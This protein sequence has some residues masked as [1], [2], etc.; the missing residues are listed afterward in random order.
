MTGSVAT[1]RQALPLEAD[2]LALGLRRLVV[3]TAT[4]P[5]VVRASHRSGPIATVLLHGAAGSWTTWT[6]LLRAAEDTGRPVRDVVAVDLPG[7]GESPPPRDR[8]LS[9]RAASTAVAQVVRTLGYAR[10]QVVGHSL[11]GFVALDLAAD[12][13]V[14]TTAVGL[15]SSTG[16][17]VVDAVRRPLVGGGRLPWFA[18][19]LLAMRTLAVLPGDGRAVLAALARLGLLPPLSSPLFADRRAVDPSVVA[20]LATEIRPTAFLDAARAAAGYD[21]GAWRAIRCPVRSVR[22][23]RDVF[24]G[25][26]DAE[27][28]TVLVP[29]ATESVIEHAGHF[30]AVE[31]PHAVLAALLPDER[32]EATPHVAARDRE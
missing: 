19:M 12:E 27:R 4:G 29:H 1:A 26:R 31:R 8:P 6:P 32:I 28:L 2:G 5:V 11:G 13:P 7:W 14:A 9:V 17:A 18:G 10:W 21:L 23:T 20:A 30:A 3:R 24:V 16:A 25:G 15:V 22:G